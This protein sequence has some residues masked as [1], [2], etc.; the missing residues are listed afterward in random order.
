MSVTHH[1]ISGLRGKWR[2]RE[3]GAARARRVFDSREEAIVF[4]RKL[5][6]QEGGQVFVHNEDG[7][8][9]DH[10]TYERRAG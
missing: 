6:Q 3:T 5:A 8:V 7:T 2:V 10:R 9:R 1:V 4:A